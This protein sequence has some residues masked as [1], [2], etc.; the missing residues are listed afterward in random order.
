MSKWDEL[1]KAVRKEEG[2]APTLPLREVYSTFA[3][4]IADTMLDLGV[5]LDAYKHAKPEEERRKAM[6]KIKEL[7]GTIHT[8]VAV[9][10]PKIEEYGHKKLRVTKD[11]MEATRRVYQFTMYETRELYPEDLPKAAKVVLRFLMVAGVLD[12]FR[13]GKIAMKGVLD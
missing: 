1:K 7:A 5:A 11:E 10:Y 4:D 6:S 8:A 3:L 2:A 9:L 13:A 12:V